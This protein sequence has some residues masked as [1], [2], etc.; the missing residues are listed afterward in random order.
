[1]LLV[2]VLQY[3]V[4]AFLCPIGRV[5]CESLGSSR[6]QASHLQDCSAPIS[7][8]A[9]RR[10]RGSM[11]SS[12]T[13]S[14]RLLPRTCDHALALPPLCRNVPQITPDNVETWDGRGPFL[15]QRQS[16]ALSRSHLISRDLN[17][18]CASLLPLGEWSCAQPPLF[19][20]QQVTSL[21]AR[22]ICGP[23][24][25]CTSANRIRLRS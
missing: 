1:M 21:V 20:M 18:T 8:V 22:C 25:S 9:S 24:A 5:H 7:T 10:F 14:K 17:S 19:S 11:V 3:D 4:H 12:D 23:D 15:Q 16:R 13:F 2:Q 6:S